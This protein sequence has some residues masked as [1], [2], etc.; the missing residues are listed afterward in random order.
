MIL[1]VGASGLVGSELCRQAGADAVGAARNIDGMATDAVDLLDRA[2]IDAALVRHAPSTVAVCSAWPYVDGCESDPVRSHRDNVETVENLIAATAGTKTR[3]LFFS[4]DH[5]FDGKKP[6][7]C[8]ESDP[9]HPLSVYARHKRE[10][11][12]RLLARGLSLICRTAWVFGIEARRKNFVYRVIGHARDRSELKVPSGQSGCPTWTGWLCE[13]ALEL[14]R[15]GTEGIVHLTGEQ[16]FTKAQ[17][18]TQIVESLGL[19]GLKLTETEW[20]LSGQIA[21]RPD[22][23]AL[24]SERHPFKQGPVDQIL[25]ALPLLHG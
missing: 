19:T 5:V 25:R 16:E 17:W 21:P 23:V 14:L 18:A 12:E 2:S 20:S 24:S 8:V 3:I 11:E 6:G 13:S 15:E 10:V 4:T 1:V 22:R 9:V 7:R